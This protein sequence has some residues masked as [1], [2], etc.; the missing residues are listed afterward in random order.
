[1]WVFSRAWLTGEITVENNRLIW[2]VKLDTWLSITSTH[3]NENS[4]GN[5]EELEI[6][7]LCRGISPE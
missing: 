5:V 3:C 6:I 7:R 1:M 4:I 2:M